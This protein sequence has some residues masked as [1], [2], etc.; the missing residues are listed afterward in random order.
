MAPVHRAL[1][2]RVAFLADGAFFS[3]LFAEF[4]HIGASTLPGLAVLPKAP[5]GS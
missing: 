2:R 3:E 4:A 5:G 1:W